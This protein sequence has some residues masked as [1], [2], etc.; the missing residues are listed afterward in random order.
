M[1]NPYR[2]SLSK[3]VIFYGLVQITKNKNKKSI[4][5]TIMVGLVFYLTKSVVGLTI[6]HMKCTFLNKILESVQIKS[7]FER[8]KWRFKNVI[9]FTS[10]KMHDYKHNLR[11]YF[12]ISH[13]LLNI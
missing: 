8:I 2:E 11:H 4:I 10:L 9:N 7:V 13:I 12:L 3:N 1:L 6:L 5:V